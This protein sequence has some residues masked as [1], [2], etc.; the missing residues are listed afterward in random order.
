MQTKG[1]NPA[2]SLRGDVSPLVEAYFDLN[3][4]K[5]LYRQGWL[6]RGIAPGYCESVAEHSFGV[7]LLA[8]FLVDAC[9]PHLD[10]D[11]VL[12]MALLH[13]F[14]EIYAGDLTPADGISD[15]EKHRLE[16]RSVARVLSKLP[17]GEVYISIWDEFERG[18]SAEARLVRQIDRLEMALQAGV[19]ERQGLADLGEFFASAEQA[20]TWPELRRILDEV[21]ALREQ[22]FIEH[23]E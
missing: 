1:I 8:L 14:G 17:G 20:I 19:Y 9:F 23:L 2:A 5:Q 7:A 16:A 3:R 11:R 13:D 22:R 10:R 12:R 4:L 6:K 21:L 18:E 15:E